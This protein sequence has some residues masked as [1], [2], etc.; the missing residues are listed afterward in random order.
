MRNLQKLLVASLVIGSAML[1]LAQVTRVE[2]FERNL[3]PHVSGEKFAGGVSG[4][5]FQKRDFYINGT[6][7]RASVTEDLLEAAPD[8]TPGHSFPLGL[9]Q[10]EAVARRELARLVTNDAPWSVTSFQL[11]AAPTRAGTKWYFV[12]EM[13]PFWQPEPGAG[14]QARDSFQLITDLSGKPGFIGK[15]NGQ[16]VQGRR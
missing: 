1:V 7:Y 5:H 4:N 10:L 6:R 12:I 8:W 9:D 14:E 11:S 13:E 15:L 16:I 2:T 3:R